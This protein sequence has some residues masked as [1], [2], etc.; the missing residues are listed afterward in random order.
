MTYDW[1]DYLD[2]SKEIINTNLKQSENGARKETL[3]RIAISRAYYAAFHKCRDYLE[4]YGDRLD[5]KSVHRD[6]IDKIDNHIQ[7]SNG[8][9]ISLELERAFHSR[10]RADYDDVFN[11][12]NKESQITIERVKKIISEISSRNVGPHR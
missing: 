10:I 2:I 9:M 11:G 4:S 7:N 6:L 8:K 1:I 5:R 3:L 12:I